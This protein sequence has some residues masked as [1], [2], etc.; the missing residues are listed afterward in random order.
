M[1]RLA[2]V[3]IAVSL[4]CFGVSCSSPDF[5]E[6]VVITDEQDPADPDPNDPNDPND[7]GGGGDPN[8]PGPDITYPVPCLG[9]AGPFPCNGYDLIGFEPTGT[10]GASGANDCWG[11]TDPDTGKEYAIYGLNNGTAF[12]DISDPSNLVFT[13]KVIANNTSIWRDIK[14]YNNYAYIVT[15]ATNS[16]MQVFDLTHLRDT[17]ILPAFY[18][19]DNTYT[20]FT[21]AH[22]IVINE[23]T[24]FAYAV[25]TN[26]FGGGPHFIDLQDPAN[27]VAA[28]GYAAGGYSHDAQAV[29][30]HGP[31]S[32][33]TDREIYIGSNEDHIEIVDVTDKSNPQFIASATY[34]GA[35]YTHQAW[36]TEDHRYLLVGDEIDEI[37]F[38]FNTK[39]IIF[40]LAN[41]DSPQHLFNYSGT[42]SSIDHN[43]YVKGNLFYLASYTA[44]LRVLDISNIANSSMNEVGYFD[45]S[46]PNDDAVF[47][48]AWSVYPYFESG[49]IVI[50]DMVSGL[51]IVKQ[52]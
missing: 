13:A 22:N 43:G 18:E 5:S 25:G 34:T 6:T 42:N 27:P 44:G 21:N 16:G 20:G 7:P 47:D 8:D 17:T 26:T 23:E 15:E 11:W 31:D 35:S 10:F 19:A 2:F 40:D 4:S 30:Y 36:L 51:F 9:M 48:G 41:L 38:G 12:V 24:G 1:I 28:G 32:D 39:T 45:V 50:S 3:L 29:I 14:V 37:D 33:Y 52:Q 46:P 49:N